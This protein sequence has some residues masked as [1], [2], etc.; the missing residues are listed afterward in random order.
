M[1]TENSTDTTATPA[2]APSTSSTLQ[3]RVE[4]DGKSTIAQPATDTKPPK[5]TRKKRAK[6]VKPVAA[7]EKKDTTATT[8]EPVTPPAPPT[9][10][11]PAKKRRRRRSKKAMAPVVDIPSTTTDQAEGT[12][13]VKKGKRGR[14]KGSG[15]KGK[16][17]SWRKG[18]QWPAQPFS[19]NLLVMTKKPKALSV[20]IRKLLWHYTVRPP[21]KS[22]KA[23][24]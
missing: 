16:K 12:A 3:E 18:R 13:P 22:K 17:G 24:A 8:Q 9:A 23:E 2:G 20:A 4:R 7:P 5:K 10:A 14:K 19:L 21:K 6:K 15:K 1:S 11:Q